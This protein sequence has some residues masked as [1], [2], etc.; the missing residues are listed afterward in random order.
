MIC[1]TISIIYL[2]TNPN[3]FHTLF[4]SDKCS[5]CSKCCAPFAHRLG[6]FNNF[7]NLSSLCPSILK[8]INSQI[9]H[10]LFIFPTNILFVAS[11]ALH[12]PPDWEF[13]K[14]G[15]P[16]AAV[17]DHHFY[18]LFHDSQ[19]TFNNL[20]D[21]FHDFHNALHN[22]HD[23]LHDF[24]NIFRDLIIL[25]MIFRNLSMIL[26]RL[27]SKVMILSMIITKLSMIC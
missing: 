23:I 19:N 22:F 18:Q 13:S 6:I 12:L 2:S 5:F 16:L 7:H 20:Y 11:V 17:L 26:I 4:Y 3:F 27:M 14:L 1:M 10:R 8:S 15:R 24:L 9:F 21:L 25:S